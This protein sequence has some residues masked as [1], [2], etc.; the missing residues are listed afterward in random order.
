MIEKLNKLIVISTRYI[1][2]VLHTPVIFIE[3][4]Q[5]NWQSKCVAESHSLK[6]LKLSLYDHNQNKIPRKNSNSTGIGNA[7]FKGDYSFGLLT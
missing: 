2:R 5:W 7:P 1:K 6:P 4:K 3:I